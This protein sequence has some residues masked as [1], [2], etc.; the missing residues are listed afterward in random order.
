MTSCSDL[1]APL[2]DLG[3]QPAREA[4]IE[5]AADRK[6]VPEGLV[7]A[8]GLRGEGFGM[9]GFGRAEAE[10]GEVEKG[11][12]QH[13]ILSRHGTGRVAVVV[14]RGAADGV[15]KHPGDDSIV[16]GARSGEA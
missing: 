7:V 6:P 3:F 14:G 4:A 2:R 8:A 13:A 9:R 1:S 12:A 5:L 11:R 16:S 15:S 10:P